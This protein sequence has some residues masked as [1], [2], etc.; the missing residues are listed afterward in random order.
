MP[1]FSTLI[2][3]PVLWVFILI[4]AGCTTA[5][6]VTDYEALYGPSEV[7]PRILSLQQQ[8]EHDKLNAISYSKDIKPI[9]DSR[10]VACH[11]CYDAPC[12]LKLGSI[13]GLDRGAS[14]QPVYDFARLEPVPPSRLFVDAKNTEEWRKKQ[15][16]PVL[17]ERQ[18][19]VLA[20]VKNSVLAKMLQLKRDHPLAEKGQLSDA[21]KLDL[22]RDL[23]CPKID[24]FEKYQHEHPQWGM[25]YAMPGLSLEDENKILTWLKQGA[26][27]DPKKPL[28]ASLNKQIIQWENY[29]NRSSNK[30]KLVARYIFE[31]LFIG[32]LHFKGPHED[33]FFKLVRSKT[34]TGQSINEIPSTRPYDDPETDVFFYRLRPVITTIVDKT[35]IVYQLN[36]KRLQR[37]DELFFQADEYEV[38]TLPSYQKEFTANPFK[39]YIDIPSHVK[40]QFLLDDAEYFVSGFIKGPSCRGQMALNSIRDRFW[41]IFLKP[42]MSYAPK[43]NQF[44]SEQAQTLNLPGTESD[45]IG[46]F[47]YR[48]YDELGY[49]YLQKKEQF[50]NQTLPKDK[51]FRLDFI[52]D[53]EGVN[54]NAALTIF[55]HFDSA[56]VTKGLIGNTPKTAWVVDYSILERLHYLLVAGFNVYGTAGHQLASRSYMD[57][58]RMDGE[59][60]FLRFMPI[61]QRQKIHESWYQGY[62][63]LRDIVPLFNIEHPSGI[64][65]QTKD[66]KKEFFTLLRKKLVNAA[67]S[68]DIINDCDE[69]SCSEKLKLSS[70]K[71]RAN[72]LMRQ[73]SS[74]KGAQIQALPEVSY[75]RVKTD[76]SANDLVYSLIFNKALSN[77]S[78]LI[79]EDARRMIDQ[80]TL[81]VTPGFI[82]SYPNIFFSVGLEQLPDFINSIK[83]AQS[84]SEQELL[85][86]RFSIRRTNP[87]FWNYADW[88]NLQHKKH[89]GLI[90]GL[91][92]LNRYH[93]R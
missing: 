53:G 39:T 64:S 63:G 48:E 61:D 25:P 14:K 33:Q 7:K 5:Y 60:N 84:D 72:Q 36:E 78:A 58:L 93:N 77:V 56:T 88:F 86:S 81:T 47:G 21:F 92:D 83:N 3:K 31:H 55:R 35:H 8:L 41:V 24:E 44:L 91:F 16:Y 29:L 76:N 73:L 65:Y 15:F 45:E 9:L 71:Q 89:R 62:T 70:E 37:Y 19:S 79:A 82:G 49:V 30:Q 74:L 80:D 67:G 13:E 27:V 66:Y 85:Y 40:Y 12:Q 54:T 23:I 28:P 57:I 90:A 1:K 87:Q 50:V 6:K 26:M 20:G 18:D 17:N 51:G 46:L 68:I 42:N 52:W 2:F 59:N 4:V 10:C 34:P 11:A 22:A 75:L 32:H 43:I 69:P 38:K